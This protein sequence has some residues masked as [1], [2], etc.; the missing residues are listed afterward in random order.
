[1]DRRTFL[2]SSGVAGLGA[3]FATPKSDYAAEQESPETFSWNTGELEFTFSLP[4]RRLRQHILLPP[5][6]QAPENS[7]RSA[8]VEVGLLRSGEDSPDSGM[9]QS[10]GS[11]SQLLQFVTRDEKQSRPGG[12]RPRA[13]DDQRANRGRATVGLRGG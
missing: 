8:G 2:I 6:I 1:M 7:A 4:Q 13:R 5:G 9:K 11:P 12:A 10:A 3:L